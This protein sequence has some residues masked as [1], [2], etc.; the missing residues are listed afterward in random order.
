MLVFASYPPQ[1]VCVILT[2]RLLWL[3]GLAAL[4]VACAQPSAQPAATAVPTAAPTAKPRAENTP[5][6]APEPT[7][8]FTPVPTGTPV[9]TPIP[10]PTT[11]PPSL[12]SPTPQPTLK[13]IIAEASAAVVRIET[14]DGSGSGFIFDPGGWVLTNAHVVGRFEEVEVILGRRFTYTG[15]VVGIDEEADIAVIKLDVAAEVPSLK[16]A[17]I[18]QVGPGDEVIAIGYPLSNILGTDPTI[19]RGVVSALRTY[20]DIEYVQTDAAINPG[21]SGG[22]LVNSRG[23]VVG[24][25]TAKLEFAGDVSVEGVGFAISIGFVDELVPFLK[26]GG[27]VRVEGL[28][29]PTPRR[30]TPTPAPRREDGASAPV[31]TLDDSG[32]E[33]YVSQSETYSINLAPDWLV[34]DLDPTLVLMS[35]SDGYS[36]MLLNSFGVFQGPLDAFVD[37][38]LDA[39]YGSLEGD[40][41][42]VEL[43]AREEVEHAS[44][45]STVKVTLRGAEY[46]GECATFITYYI[47]LADAYGYALTSVACEGDT[48]NLLVTETMLQS[49]RAGAGAV[50]PPTPEPEPSSEWQTFV[51]EEARYAIDLAPGWVA[52]TADPTYVDVSRDEGFGRFYVFHYDA[53]GFTLDT[54]ADWQV[55]SSQD[56]A[57]SLALEFELVGRSEIEHPSGLPA[58]EL[59]FTFTGSAEF[60]DSY[61]HALVFLV[62]TSGYVL[63]GRS[64]ETDLDFYFSDIEAMQDTFRPE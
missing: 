51:N 38:Q 29:T 35:S 60:C 6:S 24:I 59:V 49:F 23:Q 42:S 2:H 52:N 46:Q 53:T 30:A 56:E 40:G 39:L 27:V 22:P 32:W 54:L 44:G 34:D 16:F 15:T 62:D 18:S 7:P 10:S 45:L 20:L 48:F 5:T 17:D 12:P 43:L 41:L 63:L 21:N 58:T 47:L 3:V 28:A 55:G 19:S 14:A 11:Q 50:E 4:L 57:A 25:N 33:T 61:S 1:G 31:E 8:T 37:L 36:L 26:A 64:C 9:P 13:E